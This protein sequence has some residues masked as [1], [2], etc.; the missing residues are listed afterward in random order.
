MNYNIVDTAISSLKADSLCIGLYENQTLCEQGKVLDKLLD[1]QLSQSISQFD[2]DSD[3]GKSFFLPLRSEHANSVI[4]LG[5]GDK[6]KLNLSSLNKAFSALASQA[7]SAK[8]KSLHCF[9]D[10]TIDGT[11]ISARQLA[12]S[13]V[14]SIS[15][16]HYTFDQYKSK[17][18]P[19][20]ILEN[21]SVVCCTADQQALSEATVIAQ[22]QARGMATTRTL[23][24]LPGNV[25]TPAYLA[26]QAL[27]LASRSNNFE[28]KVLE[29]SDMEALNMGAFLSVSKGSSEPGKMIILEYKGGK[30]GDAPHMLV[31]KGITFDT[32][33]IS[34]KPGPQMDEMKYDMCGAASVIGTMTAIADL[35]PKMNIVC[36]IAA[37][38]NMPAG[39][40]SKPGDIVTTASGQTVEILNTDAEGRLVLCDAL[41][42]AKNYKPA[43][44]IDIATLTGACIIAL[45]HSTSAVMGNDDTLVDELLQSGKEVNDKAWQ[46]PIWDEYQEQIESPFADIQN[47]GGKGA[48]SITAA[49]FLSRFTKEYKWA[50]LDIAGTAWVSGGKD[51]GATGRPVPLLLNYLLSKA[52]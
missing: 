46:L 5:M 23:G 42:Y 21:I 14:R 12:N 30:E 34:L 36:I 24:N 40:A 51:K 8:V 52:S 48:G 6:K 25:C 13:L 29:E 4:L 27:A 17:K 49:C 22:A 44:V 47:I 35:Q 37:A 18:S 20:I 31:G 50:H 45:G 1:G 7:K 10:N 3:S 43:S 11:D 16:Q 26:E 39:H 38:E 2:I 28:V 33:G 15:D 19:A 32:G 9:L 41:T